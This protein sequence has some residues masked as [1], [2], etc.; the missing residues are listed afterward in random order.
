MEGGLLRRQKK[1][2]HDA[3]E[4]KVVGPGAG[5]HG[6]EIVVS[7]YLEKLLDD[8]KKTSLTLDYLRG[9]ERI[10]IPQKRRDS[11]KGALKIRGGK[12]F[13]IKDMNVDI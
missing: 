9:D 7:G 2:P 10:E 13:N 8:K 3:Q 1:E 6:G 12:I 4:K 11:D 5:I